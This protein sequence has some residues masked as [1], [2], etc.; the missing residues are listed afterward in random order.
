MMLAGCSVGAVLPAS[1]VITVTGDI[2]VRGNE[3]FT[4]VVL[5]TQENNWYVLDLTRDQR[6]AL[7]TPARARVTGILR[8]GEW[9]GRPFTRLKVDELVPIL[10]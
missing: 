8:L 1:D 9:N 6:A 5:I 10:E 7:M 2:T 3:P 4:E